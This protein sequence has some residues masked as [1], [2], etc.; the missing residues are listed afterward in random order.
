MPRV[1]GAVWVPLDL[2]ML[3]LHD[4]TVFDADERRCPKCGG[5]S[6]VSLASWLSRG[7]APHDSGLEAN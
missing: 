5:E 7:Q 1:L 6:F 4:E 2:A 3:C